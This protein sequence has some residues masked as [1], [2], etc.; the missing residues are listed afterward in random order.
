MCRVIAKGKLLEMATTKADTLKKATELESKLKGKQYLQ[1]DKP[2][3][4]DIKAFNELLGENNAN[5]ARWV[6]HMASFTAEERASWGAPSGK[7]TPITKRA[8]P[9]Q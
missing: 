2:S 8:D 6:K 3:A 5:L 7:A 4:A 1:G 9:N